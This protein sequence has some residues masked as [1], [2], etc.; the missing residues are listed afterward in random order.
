MSPEH[1]GKVP[2]E[3]VQ[4]VL[5]ATTADSGMSTRPFTD[6]FATNTWR[7]QSRDD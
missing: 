3:P 7:R 5:C 1:P 2:S 4:I 6:P